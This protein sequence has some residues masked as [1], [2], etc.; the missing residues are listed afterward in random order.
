MDSIGDIAAA[1][2]VGIAASEQALTSTILIGPNV[3][4]LSAGPNVPLYVGRRRSF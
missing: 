2:R 3:E 4:T 1:I